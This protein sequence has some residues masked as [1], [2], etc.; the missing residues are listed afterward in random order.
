M[1]YSNVGRVGPLLALALVSCGAH[2]SRVRITVDA[3]GLDVAA[4]TL[5]ATLSDNQRTAHVDVRPPIRLPATVTVLLDNVAH[6]VVVTATGVRSDGSALAGG[7]MVRSQPGH[8][9]ALDILLTAPIANPDLATEPADLATSND[10]ATGDFST[11]TPRDLT[12]PPDMTSFFVDDTFVR[13]DQPAWG[14]ASDGLAWTQDA[15]NTAVFSIKANRGVAANGAY[16]NAILGGIIAN[17]E[18]Y[19]ACSLSDV[20]GNAQCSSA[21][22]WQDALH[23]YRARIDGTNL[24][25]NLKN[26]S[27]SETVLGTYP[28]ALTAGTLYAIRFQAINNN[29]NARVWDASASEPTTWQISVTDPTYASGNVGLHGRCANSSSVTYSRFYVI[30]R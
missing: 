23:F 16:F 10:L 22:R 30:A 4:L 1:E 6:T 20:N 28:F 27:G 17:A 5:T 8:D 29:L 15:T 18:G 2:G 13:P 9:V 11:T 21:L 19:V 12:A 7:G 3:P 14:T 26:G 24:S 25:L